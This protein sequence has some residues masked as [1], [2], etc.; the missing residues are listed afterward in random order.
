MLRGNALTL[1]VNEKLDK[2][3]NSDFPADETCP[4]YTE[5]FGLVYRIEH[6]TADEV[7]RVYIITVTDGNYNMYT[8]PCTETYVQNLN[9]KITKFAQVA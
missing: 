7:S 8:M 6:V 5:I 9:T 3:N 1:E 4:W 2:I